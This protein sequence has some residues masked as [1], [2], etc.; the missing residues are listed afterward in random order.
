MDATEMPGPSTLPVPRYG[1]S[2]W[3]H[4]CGS[5]RRAG[6]IGGSV[7]GDREGGARQAAQQR[8]SQRRLGKRCQPAVLI[9]LSAMLICT[10]GPILRTRASAF[11]ED[12]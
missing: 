10:A 1:A 2:R 7:L 5:A 12:R 3:S 4:V 11:I 6:L 8:V 9:R